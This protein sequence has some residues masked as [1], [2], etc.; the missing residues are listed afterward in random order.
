[1]KRLWAPW[2]MQYIEG[3]K[4]PGCIFC[5]DPEFDADR[6]VLRREE[7][8]LVMLNRYPYTN[9]HVM[10]VPTAHVHRPHLLSAEASAALHV[11]L[12]RS[13]EALEA[14]Y[15]CEGMNL[16]MNLGRVAGA[17]VDDHVHYHIVPRWNGDHNFIPV[18]GDCRIMNEH[19]DET[20][21]KLKPVFD[22]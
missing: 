5:F 12:M 16:G 10:V 4:E 1:M 19:L 14:H 18:L 15:G 3:P 8:A 6:H 9:G 13:A 7:H 22:W 20:Y 2:R 17:G 11:L 21:Q